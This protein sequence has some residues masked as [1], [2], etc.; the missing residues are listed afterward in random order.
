[1]MRSFPGFLG[2]LLPFIFL[3]SGA[4]QA[5]QCG[6]TD[7]PFAAY[8]GQQEVG[9]EWHISMVSADHEDHGLHLSEGDTFILKASMDCEVVMIPGPLLAQRWGNSHQHLGRENKAIDHRTISNELCTTMGLSHGHAD[10]DDVISRPHLVRL[11]LIG[12]ASDPRIEIAYGHRST[13]AD[14]CSN[15]GLLDSIHGGIAH[16]EN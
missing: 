5:A 10:A 7:D 8:Y 15:D 12:N 3:F 9:K 6:D 14:N 11:R 1:M 16:G 4:A 2:L 13:M